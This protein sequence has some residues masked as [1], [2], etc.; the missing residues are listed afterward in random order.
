MNSKF[1]YIKKN[2]EII[3]NMI[4]SNLPKMEIARV[5]NVKYETLNK[6]LKKM[7]IDYKGN[8]SRKGISHI[9]SKTSVYSYLNKD[10]KTVSASLLR[11]KLI[12]SGL[13]EERCEQCKRTEWEGQKIPLELHHINMNHYDNRLENLQILCSNCHALAHGYSNVKNKSKS[14]INI[15]LYEKLLGSKK[16]DCESSFSNVKRSEPIA[17][18][19]CKKCGKKL[20]KTQ[21][22]FCSQKC[23]HDFIS[24]KPEKEELINNYKLLKGNKTKLGSLYSVSDN[25]VKKWLKSYNII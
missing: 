1:E 13:K 19:Y 18:R 10:N 9:E 22:I 11:N 23:S 8:Q 5:L 16:N 17:E 21:K 2:I 14:K 7:G 6:S 12:E 20:T 24:K 25:A 15:E 4:N 3:M